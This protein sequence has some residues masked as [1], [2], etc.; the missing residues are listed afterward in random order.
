MMGAAGSKSRSRPDPCGSRIGETLMIAL[1][2]ALC[3]VCLGAARSAAPMVVEAENFEGLGLDDSDHWTLEYSPEASMGKQIRTA[4]GKPCEVRRQIAVP[5]GQYI[6]WARSWNNGNA[7]RGN[8]LYLGDAGPLRFGNHKQSGNWWERLG[9]L[10]LPAKF[11][12]RIAVVPGTTG[13]VHKVDAIALTTD[14]R[15]D[16]NAPAALPE[17]ADAL[18]SPP[19]WNDGRWFVAAGSTWATSISYLNPAPRAAGNCALRLD[20]PRGVEIEFGCL[21]KP[22][23]AGDDA[24]RPAWWPD[25]RVARETFEEDGQVWTRY[26][27]RFSPGFVM[28]A[29]YG[30][31]DHNQIMWTR[32]YAPVTVFARVGLAPGQYEF[33]THFTSSQGESPPHAIRVTVLPALGRQSP[34]P[35]AHV[36]LWEMWRS[37]DQV[38]VEAVAE[39]FRTLADIGFNELHIAEPDRQTVTLAGQAGLRVLDSGQQPLEKP[40]GAHPEASAVGVDGRPQPRYWC[41]TYL[42]AEQA[43][44]KESLDRVVAPLKLGCAGLYLD[45]EGPG[46]SICYCKRCRDAFVKATGL[47]DVKWP[48]DV[49]AGGRYFEPH[50]VEFRIAQLNQVLRAIRRRLSAAS[51]D[52]LLGSYSGWSCLGSPAGHFEVENYRYGYGADVAKQVGLLGFF[53][54]GFYA[55]ADGADTG[56]AETLT[57][58][59]RSIGRAPL[60]PYLCDEWLLPEKDYW[61]PNTLFPCEIIRSEAGI[62]LGFGCVGI[63]IYLSQRCDA[64]FAAL[65]NRQARLLAALGRD[66]VNA[67]QCNELLN[68]ENF[69]GLALA[70][71][72]KDKLWCVLVPAL[73]QTRPETVSVQLGGA[74]IRSGRDVDTG[75]PLSSDSGRVQAAV[76][77]HDFV[78]CELTVGDP[79]R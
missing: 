23:F 29:N 28:P 73:A 54:P 24:T 50:W 74:T 18:F 38:A 35:W 5:P 22:W 48:D 44:A 64:R 39:Y 14:E 78:V 79:A 2:S 11:E 71:R 56:F 55:Y 8:L 67:R 59:R 53:A 19:Q 1:S 60:S 69:H 36:G 33:R 15:W 4:A 63:N 57:R 75:R 6:V 43:G 31:E 3:A 17:K 9:R 30:T 49:R 52:A 7:N 16:P 76:P 34:P 66:F 26:T 27:L 61:R 41:P 68:A 77:P 21:D 65:V 32:Q 42:V 47:R 70:R 12:A 58:M 13:C 62:A 45:W 46:V 25:H 51:P 72:S 10:S 37:S 40:V 20:V